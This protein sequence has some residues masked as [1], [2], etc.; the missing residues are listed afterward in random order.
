MFTK[1]SLF[2]LTVLLFGAGI[3]WAVKSSS[4][5]RNP[6]SRYERIFQLLGELLEDGHFSP[7][8]MDDQFSSQ[9]FRK[10]L[11]TLDPDKIYFLASDID[12]L[13]KVETRIDDEIKGDKLESF[14]AINEIYK[15]RVEEAS[16]IYKQILKKPFDFTT[17]EIYVEA[18]ETTNYPRNE[19]ARTEAWRKRLKYAVLDRYVELEDQQEKKSDSLKT[20]K[21][22]SKELEAEAREKVEKIYNRIFERFKN[23]FKDE[24]R[25]HWMVNDIAETMDPHTSYYPPVE[26]RSFDEQMSGEFFGIGASLQEEDGNIKIATI[27]SGSPAQKSGEINI[28]DFIIKVAQGEEEPQDLT[29]FVVEDAVK[30]IRGKKGTEVRLTLKKTDGSI[31]VISLIRE[32]INLEETYAKSVIIK[33]EDN[34]R[35]GYIYLPEFYANFQDPNGARCA[36]DVRKEILKLKEEN[37]SGM[38]MDLRTNGGGSLM[39]VVQ[40]VGFF[41]DQGPVVQVKSKDDPPTILKD[42]EPGT[43]WDGPLTVMVNEFSASAS[44]IFAAAIQDYKRGI[45]VGSTSTF[46]KGTVQRT[47]ELDRMAWMTNP[48]GTDELGSIKLTIQKFYRINGGS[49][50]LNGV[51]PDIILPD[52]YEYLKMREKDEKTALPWDEINPA[53]FTPCKNKY[54]FSEIVGN[55]QKRVADNSVFAQLKFYVKKLEKFNNEKV[56]SLKMDIYKSEKKA[57]AA[58]VKAMDTLLKLPTPLELV[59]L[60]QDMNRIGKDSM[61]IE[62]NTQFLKVRKTDIHLGETVNIMNDMIRLSLLARKEQK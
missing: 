43:L 37:I 56:Y 40:M 16:L 39:D 57:M 55:S 21:K 28:G 50:Q 7:K 24:D 20:T 15:K 47:M 52:Q 31:K 60:R 26:K 59:N 46:G 25:F 14:Y 10:Y 36:N 53:I 6:Q 8:K 51:V 19:A 44:E 42:N 58:S 1:K 13:K 9:V 5:Y 3:F 54:A 61:K 4:T 18:T 22:S 35:I 33:G 41:I 12:K 23:R 30:L 62:R 34:Q 2:L 11:K 45:V 38:I 17:D 32:K 27:V 48:T 49:T 29:G